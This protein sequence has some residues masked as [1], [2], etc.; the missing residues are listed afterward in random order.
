MGK[1]Q[2]DIFVLFTPSSGSSFAS[3]KCLFPSPAFPSPTGGPRPEPWGSDGPRPEPWGSDRA[4]PEPWGSSGQPGKRGSGWGGH[5]KQTHARGSRA[6]PPIARRGRGVPAGGHGAGRASA[7]AAASHPGSLRAEHWLESHGTFFGVIASFCVEI[8]YR[9]P[10]GEMAARL[11]LVWLP[12]G[13][14]AAAAGG[15]GWGVSL[16]RE[17]PIAVTRCR[18]VTRVGQ[19]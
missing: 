18:E 15:M 12:R 9:N 6:R 8:N 11:D 13:E 3:T 7:S 14:A 16:L 4:Q 10:H 1:S 17:V 19:R 2:L 5:P